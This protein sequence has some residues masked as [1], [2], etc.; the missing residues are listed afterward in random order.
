MTK[1]LISFVIGLIIVLSTLDLQAQ[2]TVSYDYDNAGNRTSRATVRLRSAETD[3]SLSGVDEE[4]I[5]TNV[6]PN[7]AVTVYPNP[8]KSQL[9]VAVTGN[10]DL[11]EHEVVL[12]ELSGRILYRATEASNEF[13]LDMKRFSAGTYFLSVRSGIEKSSFTIIKE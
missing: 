8:V 10:T 6:T 2:T 5:R 11:S 13:R 1:H 9:T 12:S 7:F 3:K 4:E